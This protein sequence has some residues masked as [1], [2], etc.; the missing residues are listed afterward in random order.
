VGQ[1]VNP[2]GFRIGYT[3]DW[4]S[5]WFASKKEFAGKLAE[6]IEIRK[7]IKGRFKEFAVSRINIERFANRV[8][9]AI[10]TARPGLVIGSKGAQIEEVKTEL[11]KLAKGKEVFLDVVEV[12]NPEV[13]AVLVAESIAQQLERRVS[14]RRAMKK[15]IQVAMDMGADGIKVKCGG[16]LSGADIARNEVYSEGRVPLQTISA[17]IDYGFAEANTTYGIIGVKVWICKPKNLE[18]NYGTNAKKGKVQ[19]GSKRQPRR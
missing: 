18:Q 15:S 17:N 12:R 5:R 6:D 8:R 14:Y 10:H 11:A 3:K 19:K 16:R 2:V 7:L 4:R 1:K 13:D 9:I